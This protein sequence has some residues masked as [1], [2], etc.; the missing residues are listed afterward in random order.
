MARV[1]RKHLSLRVKSCKGD[2]RQRV[3]GH[4]PRRSAKRASSRD[5]QGRRLQPAK[6]VAGKRGW[7][8]GPAQSRLEHSLRV[9]QTYGENMRDEWLSERE[10]RAV[11]LRVPVPCVDVLPYRRSETGEDEVGLIFRKTPKL[12]RRWCLVGG[13]LLINESFRAAIVRQVREALGSAVRCD[14]ALPAMPIFVAEYFSRRRKGAPFDPRQ[15]AI[16]LTFLVG[17]RGQVEAMGE[18]EDFRWFELKDLP[19]PALFGFGQHKVVEE[20]IRRARLFKSIPT[21]VRAGRGETVA[22]R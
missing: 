13:R 17:L 3:V 4:L 5:Q 19:K 18:A 11:Q 16:G 20:T 21:P 7:I 10:W 22:R 15:H 8:V 9:K 1:E 2:C 6:A 14:L 12:G